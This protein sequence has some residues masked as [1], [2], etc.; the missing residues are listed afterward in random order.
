MVR[1]LE[2]VL[3]ITSAT[4]ISSSPKY[5]LFPTLIFRAGSTNT[6]H[7]NCS[8][9]SSLNKNTSIFAPVF[10]LVAH[11]LAGMTLVLLIKIK[12]SSAK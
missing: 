12:S 8:E 3:S 1:P 5:N 9:L 11:I 2:V 6:S 4:K 10:S 7:T